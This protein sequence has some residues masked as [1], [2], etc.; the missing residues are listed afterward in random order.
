VHARDTAARSSSRTIHEGEAD[1]GAAWR[2][3]AIA[4]SKP[5]IAIGSR[6]RA[7]VGTPLA[8]ATYLT[9]RA[10][11]FETK[12]AIRRSPT[13]FDLRSS[14]RPQMPGAAQC[15]YCT[16]RA[17]PGLTVRDTVLPD[18]RPLRGGVVVKDLLARG[19]VASLTWCSA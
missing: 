8:R 7:D 17:E 15:R 6:L 13:R 16:F 4:P 14:A 9:A 12:D 3:A 19:I 10:G 5:L 11:A 1:G 18:P 2:C